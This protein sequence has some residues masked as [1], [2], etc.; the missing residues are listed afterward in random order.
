M[1]SVNSSAQC[2]PYNYHLLQAP[3]SE[4][5]EMSHERHND[6]NVR[7][8]HHRNMYG[9]SRDEKG[10]VTNIDPSDRFI[11]Y[12]PKTIQCGPSCGSRQIPLRI[13]TIESPPSP[14][15]PPNRPAAPASFF[16]PVP[17]SAVKSKHDIHSR[18]ADRDTLAAST[19]LKTTI[20]RPRPKSSKVE[21]E[22]LA[23]KA[24]SYTTPDGR[25]HELDDEAIAK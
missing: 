19:P 8:A 1:S 10:N 24:P 25:Q 3:S 12:T 6:S 23:L 4:Q 7:Y 18:K 14:P 15:P 20:T 22:R 9:H 13:I 11:N 5:A 21:Q 16:D 17:D 2:D